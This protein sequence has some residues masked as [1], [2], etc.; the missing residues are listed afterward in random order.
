MGSNPFYHT[1]PIRQREHF[2]NREREVT[3]AIDRL[4]HLQ[5]LSITG[6]R[7][8]GKTSLLFHLRDEP[9]LDPSQHVFVYV[10]CEGLGSLRQVEMYELLFEEILEE[11]NGRRAASEMPAVS[12]PITFYQIKR[13]V[14]WVSR[15]GLSL[16]LALDEFEWVSGNEH[17]D[18]DFFSSLRALSHYVTFVTTSR[19]PLLNL[20]HNDLYSPFFNIFARLPLGLF[21][22]TDSRGL[23]ESYLAKADLDLAPE[24]IDLTLELGGGHPFFLQVAGYYAYELRLM[25]GR[26]L[27]EHDY[28]L[29]KE[30]ARLQMD[31]HFQYI[32][33]HLDP[34]QRYALAAL[35]LTQEA[36]HLKTSFDQLAEQGV[37]VPHRDGWRIFSPLFREFVCGQSVENVLNV[38]PFL[39]ELDQKQAL[40]RGYPLDLSP[41]QFTLLAYLMQHRDRVV[42]HSEL[43]QEISQLHTPP[44]DPKPDPDTERVKSIIKHL[45]KALGDDDQCIVTVRGV[46]YVFCNYSDN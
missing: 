35:P 23:I 3:W 26:A 1:G 33:D 21:T 8:I 2:Y 7:K 30:H 28:P 32:W 29:L 20:P 4:R 45:R 43:D 17:L 46:G 5:S 12:R 36:S 37:V 42:T 34:V 40:L 24:T 22:P 44:P 15:Q 10:N 18:I 27:D 38:G 14:R 9:G 39:L 41:S 11:L 19:Q 6:P 16:I 25:A 31:Q 13:F